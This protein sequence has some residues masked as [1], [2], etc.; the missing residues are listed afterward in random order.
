MRLR[1]AALSTA[2]AATALAAAPTA[3]E[4]QNCTPSRAMLVLDRSSSMQTGTIGGVSK[5]EIAVDAIDTLV[6][7]FDT[8]IELGLNVFPEP[9]QCSPGVTRVQP[10]LS[11]G[12]DIMSELQAPPPNAGNWTPMA[13]TLSAVA[14]ETSLTSP[15]APAYAVLVTDGWQWCDPY[16]PDTRF[17]PVDSINELNAAGITTYVVG[18]GGAVDALALNQMAVEAGTARPGCDPSGS[19][20]G[21]SD[22]CYYSASSPAELVAALTDI[23]VTVSTETCDGLDND[24]DGEIDEDLTRAC[25]SACGAGT[26]T[27][28]MGNWEGCDAP[29]VETDVCDGQDNDCDGT[30]DPGCDC[31]V[32]ETRDCGD[33]SACEPGTQTC[34]SDGTWGDCEG[35]VYPEPEMCDGEDNDCDGSTDEMDD[36]VGNLCG[37]GYTC[38]PSGNCEELPPEEPPGDDDDG[39]DDFGADGGGPA[40]G[41][42]CQSTDLGG[43]AGNGLLVLLGALILGARRRRR[44]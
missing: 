40:G 33:P 41:C 32:G 44:G 16:D 31:A 19:T 10:G 18:F 3:A 9:D 29:P 38:T 1:T 15:G 12:A 30:T 21:L 35:A 2:L 4:A 37:P 8:K 27:C 13:Q 5:W 7:Q 20:P 11:N 28:V 22:A 43:A 23:G 14:Q 17:D 42:G 24:C 34:A 36:D 39:G 6:G 26:E 25:S